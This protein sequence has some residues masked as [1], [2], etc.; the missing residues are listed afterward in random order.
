MVSIEIDS[1]ADLLCNIKEAMQTH[2]YTKSETDKKYSEKTHTHPI[3]D[4]LKANSTYPVQNK[5]V[6]AAIDDKAPTSHTHSISNITGLRGELDD[7]AESDHNHDT[8][9]Y[10]QSVVDDKLL[11]KA[12]NEH[13]HDIED[14]TDLQLIL[15]NKAPLSHNHDDRYFTEGEVTT[16]LATKSD[17]THNHNNTYVQI[18]DFNNLNDKFN[19]RNAVRARL[20]RARPDFT[21]YPQDTEL[22]NE[23]AILEVN[24]GDK[25]G[26]QLYS[27]DPSISLANRIV[28]IYIGGT[29][30]MFTT[31]NKGLTTD[32]VGLNNG[33]NNVAFAILK[34]TEDFYKD[35][36]VKYIKYNS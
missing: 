3:D 33:N 24:V 14:V 11:F 30:R 4:E 18:A 31:N 32:M 23:A 17:K 26:V 35:V 6:K 20:I 10:A 22:T 13:T 16:K 27:S 15:I 2:F 8:R 28:H 36:D 5:V 7:K 21:P 19:H 25:L 9:Y 12:D 29:E 1:L 34:G